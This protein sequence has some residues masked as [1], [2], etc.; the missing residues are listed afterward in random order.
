MKHQ[1][2]PMTKL[3]ELLDDNLSGKTVALWGL[4]F[5]PRTDDIREAP[6]LVLINRLLDAGATIRVFDPEAME[7]VKQVFGD[8]LTY[9]DHGYD[10]V[11][12]A[13][14]LVIVTEWQEFHNPRTEILKQLMN[15]PIIV[16]GRNL[17]DPIH[18]ARLGFTYASVGRQTVTPN[19]AP[20]TVSVPAEEA[21]A[22]Y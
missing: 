3:L 17:Y 15:R 19:K 21:A 8:R 10:A 20:E 1:G 5:K 22:A 7:N 14:A 11:K 9:C 12:G 4:A 16:D 6:S 2:I 18:M 13:D